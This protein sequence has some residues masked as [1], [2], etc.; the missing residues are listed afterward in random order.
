VQEQHDEYDICLLEIGPANPGL[1]C[2]APLTFWAPW[3]KT[4]GGLL[5]LNCSIMLLPV[6]KGFIRAL[7]NC[8]CGTTS[9]AS[10]LPLRKHLTFHRYVA[11]VVFVLASVHTFAHFMNYAYRPDETLDTFPATED[12]ATNTREQPWFG[13]V[14]TAPWYTGAAIC[15]AMLVIYSGAVTAVRRSAYWLF[16]ACHHAFAVF[17]VC[18]LFHGP[19]AIWWC[20]VPLLLYA[21]ERL[22]RVARGQKVVFLR[23]VRWLDPV[24]ALEFAPEDRDAFQFVEGQYLYLS[25]PA[26]EGDSYHPFTISSSVGDRD[27]LG[28]I[29]CHIRVHPGGWTER[30]KDYLVQFNPRQEFPLV[31]H[32]YDESGRRQVGKAVGPDGLPILRVDGCFSAPS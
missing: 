15:V 28:Y 5:N 18:L 22:W 6:L 4:T 20:G 31:L 30:V 8:H 26:V 1:E 12:P 27:N 16:W 24:L 23:A 13:T 3:A 29:T 25:V 21:A 17:Y 32:R 14:R 2:T 7:N 10:L 9:L 19:V 11:V